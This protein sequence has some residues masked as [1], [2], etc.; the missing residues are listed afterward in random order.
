MSSRL[1]EGES[2]VVIQ[3]QATKQKAIP[4]DG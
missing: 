3:H 1:N 4:E 2:D